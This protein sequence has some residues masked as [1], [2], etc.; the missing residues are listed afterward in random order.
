MDKVELYIQKQ[1][2]AIFGELLNEIEQNKAKLIAAKEF[3]CHETETLL[4]VAAKNHDLLMYR[5]QDYKKCVARET[6]LKQVLKIFNIKKDEY[7]YFEYPETI[8]TSLN[9]IIAVIVD[10]EE[11]EMAQELNIWRKKL[12]KIC[13]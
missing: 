12:T 2:F 8:L 1:L 6:A 4:H 3:Q 13:A 9:N 10:Y 5:R 11:Y 7:G